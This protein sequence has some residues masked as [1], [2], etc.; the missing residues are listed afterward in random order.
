MWWPVSGTSESTR[1]D[2][3]RLDEPRLAPLAPEEMPEDIAK[4][5]GDF[6]DK[7]AV[8]AVDPQ[9]ER[10]DPELH[11]AMTMEESGEVAPGTVLRVMQKGYLLNDRLLRPALVVVAK[12]ADGGA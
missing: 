4:M 12:A 6:L 10:F 9:G 11:Q 8:K 7:M 2:E 3:M 1:E 5:F